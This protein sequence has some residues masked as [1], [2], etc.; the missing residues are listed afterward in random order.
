MDRCVWRRG[1]GALVTDRR[2]WTSELLYLRSTYLEGQYTLVPPLTDDD[3][4]DDWGEKSME[5]GGERERENR[6]ST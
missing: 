5:R 3:D 1:K 4:D 2:T 6:V